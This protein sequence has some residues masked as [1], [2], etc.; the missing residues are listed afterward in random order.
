MKTVIRLCIR[1]RCFTKSS[2][3]PTYFTVPDR[4]LFI[5]FKD[6]LGPVA[7]VCRGGGKI[8]VRPQS[9]I[10]ATRQFYANF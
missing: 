3:L 8:I 9:G 7:N 2:P 6:G 4:S 10:M 5:I 1:L